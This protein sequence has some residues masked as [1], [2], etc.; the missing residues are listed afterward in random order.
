MDALFK[1]LREEPHAGVRAVL[2]HF[3]FVYIHPYM[4]G[5]GRLG[6]FLMNV[7]FA[8]GGYPW[9]V[10][11]VSHRN[12]YLKTLEAASVDMQ[13]LTLHSFCS[14]YYDE[15]KAPSG[16]RDTGF[17]PFLGP[18]GRYCNRPGHIGPY[19]PHLEYR[20]IPAVNSSRRI[21][22]FAMSL[23]NCPEIHIP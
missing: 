12:E 21:K 16:T 17:Y 8:S 15:S 6:R 20:A 5:N 11:E 3:I 1:C 9:T 2:G 22:R 14:C 4:D 23:P 18:K 19:R 13:Y 10:I 7:M